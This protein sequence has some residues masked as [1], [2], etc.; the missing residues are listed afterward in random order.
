L[1]PS[2]MQA[3]AIPRRSP[4]TFRAGGTQMTKCGEADRNWSLPVAACRSRAAVEVRKL[5]SRLS[6][7]KPFAPRLGR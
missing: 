6:H 5:T 2:R 7:E 3:S 1:N 4:K